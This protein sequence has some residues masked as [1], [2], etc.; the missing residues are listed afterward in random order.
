[1]CISGLNFEVSCIQITF[2]VTD[3]FSMHLSG[4]VITK[5]QQQ[6][7]QAD[8]IPGGY[9]GALQVLDKGVNKPFKDKL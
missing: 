9:T 8:I 6:G 7:T 4:E 5:I 1:M 3:E 2:V